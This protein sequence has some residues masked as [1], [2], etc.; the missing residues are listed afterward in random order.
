M[1]R[2][3][4]RLI[5]A[6]VAAATM[7]AG[8]EKG[9]EEYGNDTGSPI[10]FEA[11][12]EWP[13]DIET[14]TEYSGVDENGHAVSSSSNYERI[15]WVAGYDRI[16]V[17]CDA[18]VGKET[19]SKKTADYSI[20]SVSVPSD[21]KKSQAGIS[22]ADDNTLQWGTGTHYF[23]ALYPAPN[24]ES[25]YGFTTY[26]PVTEANAKIESVTGN[27]AKITGVIP[28]S[29][30]SVKQGNIFKANMNYAYMYA[31]AQGT[32]GSTSRVVL[33]FYPLVTTVEVRLKGISSDLISSKL[34][35]LE[36][37]SAT[38][39]LT[40]TF[41]ATVSASDNPTI[42]TTGTTGKKITITVPNGGTTLSATEAQTFTFLALPVEQKD[43]T[44]TLNFANGTTRKLA[45]KK[46]GSF[47]TVPACKKVYFDNLGVPNSMYYLDVVGPTASIGPEGGSRG[48]TVKSYVNKNGGNS[49]VTWTAQFSTDNG[50]TWSNT[51][52]SWLTGFT[53]SDTGSLTDKAYTATA[54]EN[55]TFTAKTWQ[56]SK[57]IVLG[58]N[59][60]ANAIDLSLRDA[61]GNTISCSTANCYVVNSPGWYKIPLVYGNAIKNGQTNTIAYSN[62][63]SAT[64]ALKNFVRHDGQPITNPWIKNNGITVT[65]AEMM[66]QDNQWVISTT[67][68]PNIANANPPSIDGD[69]LYFYV[70]EGYIKQCNAVLAAKDASGTIVW[71]WHIWVLDKLEYLDTVS[72]ISPDSVLNPVKIAKVNLGWYDAEQLTHPRSV[73]VKFT[74]AESG[75]TGEFTIFQ[76]QQMPH[77]GNMYYQW[78]RKDPA[79]GATDD[80]GAVHA[81]FATSSANYFDIK[82]LQ[83]VSIGESIKHPN[84]FYTNYE[85]GH[86]TDSN[87]CTVC[88]DG[89]NYY[90]WCSSRYDNLWNANGKY[91]QDI[92]VVKTVYDPCPY[93]FKVPNMEAFSA[94]YGSH[95]A[96][97]W[98]FGIVIKNA[99]TGGQELFFPCTSLREAGSGEIRT[100]FY[101]CYANTAAVSYHSNSTAAVTNM[102]SRYLQ[103]NEPSNDGHTPQDGAPVTIGLS[104][105]GGQSYGFPVR[106]IAE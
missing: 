7:A 46:N 52:P 20:H 103:I 50:A 10:Q 60:K 36:L 98:N 73:K 75:L 47:I 70:N 23:Y 56:A 96:N 71:S 72:V 89:L 106:P 48:Y 64:Y 63:N 76:M 38:T 80:L 4:T 53:S 6:A 51:K 16:R 40:G 32:P 27:K 37:S 95:S 24:M 39:A 44:L 54:S 77:G 78:G 13:N 93:G 69:Y 41:N 1:K 28:A 8:C 61:K 68:D 101:S 104:R 22:A 31:R 25:K 97:E 3:V 58:N 105:T 62:S 26:N 49:P 19:A 85:G 30:Q 17:L 15:D 12:S 59:S 92:A 74:Q 84:Y 67:G 14:R 18:A 29:Q 2:N 66:W 87:L 34:T 102:S 79:L 83:R 94:L 82:L 99:A 21:K 57:L 65:S 43:L 100:W 91:D 45:L 55:N 90:G 86:N 81:Q 33:P 9:L 88:S 42:A 11:S 35:S 5:L